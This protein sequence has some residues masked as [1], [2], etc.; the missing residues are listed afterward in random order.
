MSG[1]ASFDKPAY[2]AGDKGVLTVVDPS[3]IKSD[4]VTIPS[5]NG[6]I[7]VSTS[8]TAPYAAPTDTMGLAFAFVS[9]DPSTGTTVW[10]FVA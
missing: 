9:D 3:R 7:T 5:V 4:T 10:D 2:N 6:N 8:V 1:T